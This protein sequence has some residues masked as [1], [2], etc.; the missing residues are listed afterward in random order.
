MEEEKKAIALTESS[1]GQG[2]LNCIIVVA[3][4][5]IML[6]CAVLPTQIELARLE[7]KDKD[8]TRAVEVLD[9]ALD[10]AKDKFGDNTAE[11]CRC[12]SLSAMPGL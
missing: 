7:M 9:A 4:C 12:L 11:A 3:L 2:L 10:M 5:S 6:C 8:F 1:A